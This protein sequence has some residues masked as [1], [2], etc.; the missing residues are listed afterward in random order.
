MSRPKGL[1]RLMAAAGALIRFSL[2]GNPIDRETP[3]RRPRSVQGLGSVAEEATS[4]AWR[5]TSCSP[6]QLPLPGVSSSGTCS[7][8]IPSEMIRLLLPPAPLP[9]THGLGWRHSWRNGPASPRVLPACVSGSTRTFCPKVT[10]AVVEQTPPK[11]LHRL[12]EAHLPCAGTMRAVAQRKPPPR[13]G[14][15]KLSQLSLPNLINQ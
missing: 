8:R 2:E 1:H 14:L 6:S 5:R 10:E 13:R 15:L 3:L 11:L 12:Q 9:Q 7:Q 4:G